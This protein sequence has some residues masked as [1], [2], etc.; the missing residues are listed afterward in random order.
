MPPQVADEVLAV[1]REALSNAARHGSPSAVEV[2]LVAG[3]ELVLTVTDDGIGLPADG[4]RSGFANLAE[5]AAMLGGG[6]DAHALPHGGTQ[7]IWRV[8]LPAV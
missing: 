1:L 3:S 4:R 5:H 8:P 7:L 6:F 2:S